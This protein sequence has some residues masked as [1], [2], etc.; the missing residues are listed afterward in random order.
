MYAT[1]TQHA[2]A[3]RDDDVNQ[4]S[5]ALKPAFADA[6]TSRKY[7]YAAKYNMIVVLASGPRPY[8]FLRVI[9][10]HMCAPWLIFLS[11]PKKKA[12][13][14][15]LKI[16]LPPRSERDRRSLTENKTAWAGIPVGITKLRPP[17]ERLGPP[18]RPGTITADLLTPKRLGGDDEV[19][20]GKIATKY[21]WIP[22]PLV[23][24]TK[25][26]QAPL[27]SR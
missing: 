11:F 13:V 15:T 8:V 14:R 7:C 9:P 5:Y 19:Q 17:T 18:P 6:V 23:G 12:G 22:A 26:L 24:K 2:S 4:N 3:A 25:L 1:S 27:K 10:G 16:L 20:L 21:N